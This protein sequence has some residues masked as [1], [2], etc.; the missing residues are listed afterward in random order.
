MIQ[1][2][3]PKIRFKELS[4][5]LVS[6]LDLESLDAPLNC[7][8][9]GVN[10][11][12]N[13]PLGAVTR[14]PGYYPSETVL[15]SPDGYSLK[16]FGR[17]SV[18]QPKASEIL[19]LYYKNDSS[20]DFKIYISPLADEGWLE[21]TQ[22]K[23]ITLTA[24][25]S[26]TLQFYEAG[27]TINDY[28][29]SI[30]YNQTQ[31]Q[32]AFARA[33][34][35]EH[36]TPPD[37][38]YTLTTV[39]LL[40][41]NGYTWAVS[42]ICTIFRSNLKAFFFLSLSD[43]VNPNFTGLLGRLR[44]GTGVGENAVAQWI[45]YL[46]NKI[47]IFGASGEGR[48]IE[49]SDFMLEP[50][51]AGMGGSFEFSYTASEVK[52]IQ[53]V[54]TLVDIEGQEVVVASKLG[55]D[56]PLILKSDDGFGFSVLFSAS[57]L[58]KRFVSLNVYANDDINES[59]FFLQGSGAVQ[60]W[61]PSSDIAVLD[62][63][64]DAPLFSKINE[65]VEED[66]TYIY[67]TGIYSPAV[68]IEKLSGLTNFG[69]LTGQS[70]SYRA[71]CWVTAEQPTPGTLQVDLYQGMTLIHTGVVNT[72]TPHGYNT[73]TDLLTSAEA[74]AITDYTDLR[75]KFTAILNGAEQVI[76]V[77][78]AQFNSLASATVIGLNSVNKLQVDYTLT[79]SES[80]RYLY[81]DPRFTATARFKSIRFLKGRTYVLSEKEDYVRYTQFNTD[82]SE[83]HDYF[84]YDEASGF[85]YFIA[86]AKTIES[87]R[88][89]AVT[90]SSNLVIFRSNSTYVYEIQ[91]SSSFFS[92]LNVLF[93]G[94]GTISQQTVDDTSDV[95]IFF[96]DYREIYQ[97]VGGIDVP[98]RLLVGRLEK[99]Y[100]SLNNL[101]KNSMI[102]K[103]NR[104]RDELW[105]LLQVFGNLGS[106]KP[107]D[108]RIFVYNTLYDN[109]KM[110]Q[111]KH[112]VGWMDNGC[113]NQVIEI[114]ANNKPQRWDY[115]SA[116]VYTH[117]GEEPPEPFL[118]THFV[119]PDIS[120]VGQL[121]EI[122]AEYACE[123][124]FRLRLIAGGQPET[125]VMNNKLFKSSK[126]RDY[127]GLMAPFIYYKFAV[128]LKFGEISGAQQINEFGVTYL[129]LG[130]KY[131]GR[132]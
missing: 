70:Y 13:D 20:N 58:T 77:S 8:K 40:L 59:V 19:I 123:Q 115:S 94:I 98:K 86:P 7:F 29:N 113:L 16:Y 51:N 1:Q 76:S 120:Q 66:S 93:N 2:E 52:Q 15:P 23:E 108:Y 84:P 132:K 88:A 10:I 107:S 106:T 47:S 122:Y 54:V 111:P 128:L 41:S 4:R 49:L 37:T 74:A 36:L 24:V 99:Y 55:L 30:I 117:D 95:G 62:G 12:I 109:W 11:E 6:T 83:I 72:L 34:S 125:T 64:R 61:K 81:Y 43:I 63:W 119:S 129:S 89:L 105:V 31:N 45:G 25:G 3:L 9:D 35:Y 65:D 73:Y 56:A 38:K 46:D 48:A 50:L 33:S 112:L 44:I 39:E 87:N 121:E 60:R 57:Q 14:S 67:A 18:E 127:I 5:G 92:A 78:W 71:K 97:Y 53:I 118:R 26:D 42:D 100:Q 130:G 101:Y 32:Y 79:Y 126:V 124:N 85:G 82:A 104:Q 22:S 90:K 96:A 75:L 131:A 102:L 114:L 110:L 116:K 21:L 27:I 80:G 103:F 17:F 69:S 68:C 28:K 91:S